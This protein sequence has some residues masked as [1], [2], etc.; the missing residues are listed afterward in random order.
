MAVA[1]EGDKTACGATLISS[2]NTTTWS[3]ESS[4]EGP[5]ADDGAEQASAASVK[6]AL[7]KSGICLDCLIKAAAAGSSIVVRD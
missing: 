7:D 1:R 3:D 2:Q 6:A 5:A 4:M